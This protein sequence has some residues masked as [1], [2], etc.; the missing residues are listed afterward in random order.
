MNFPI[1]NIFTDSNLPAV[2]SG[3]GG[4]SGNKYGIPMGL[5]LLHQP[6]IDSTI[7]NTNIIRNK[8]GG[9]IHKT[10]Y[11][12][13]LQFH[14]TNNT[15]SSQTNKIKKNNKIKKTKKNKKKSKNTTK[16]YKKL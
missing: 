13:L 7:S 8:E 10:L 12:S 16:K 15:A 11:D 14:Q 1:T 2:I 9:S 5:A 6:P 3:G 4:R